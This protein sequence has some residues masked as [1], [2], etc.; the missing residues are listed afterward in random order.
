MVRQRLRIKVL[1]AVRQL[2]ALHVDAV[3]EAVQ[4]L[5]A[6]ISQQMAAVTV[7]QAKLQQLQDRQHFTEAVG[8]GVIL[9]A[10]VKTELVVPVLAAMLAQRMAIMQV[11][12]ELQ[13][14]VQAEAGL[15]KRHLELIC[16]AVLAVQA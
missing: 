12:Q 9:A 4:A 16:Q 6:Q 15:L 14:L 3:A 11:L 10:A 5:L 2:L 7:A 13:I 8:A 1:M